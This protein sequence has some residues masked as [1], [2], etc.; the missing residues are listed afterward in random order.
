MRPTSNLKWLQGWGYYA[1]ALIFIVYLTLYSVAYAGGSDGQDNYDRLDGTGSSGKKVHVIEWEG[2]LEIH[3]SP[4]GSLRGLGLKLDQREKGKTVMVISY[5]F[6]TNPKS[7]LIRRAI[8]GIPF[9]EGFKT[10]RDPS[11]PDYDKIIVSNNGL[12]QPLIAYQLDSEPSQLYPEGHPALAKKEEGE[13]DRKPAF[14]QP[15]SSPGKS[16]KPASVD[17]EEEGRVKPFFM[18]GE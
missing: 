8:L 16:R 9:S 18:N 5:R 15:K 17:D 6:D 14:S 10:Y 13:A 12:A 1:C 2:N 7:P 3:V 4:K 11:E